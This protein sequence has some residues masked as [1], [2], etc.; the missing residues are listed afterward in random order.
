MLLHPIIFSLCAASSALVTLYSVHLVSTP[1]LICWIGVVVTAIPPYFYLA[2]FAHAKS[3][4]F[5]LLCTIVRAQSLLRF[6]R[7]LFL[8]FRLT[9]IFP[10]MLTKL[11]AIV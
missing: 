8:I 2:S 3:H 4:L 1:G 11:Y 7:M 10:I 5:R 9:I 6:D